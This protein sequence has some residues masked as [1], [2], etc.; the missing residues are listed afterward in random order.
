MNLS[1]E[2]SFVSSERIGRL[3]GY[4][5]SLCAPGAWPTRGDLDPAEIKDLLPYIVISEIELETG[6]VFYR[7]VGTKIVQVS[8]ID[9]TGH[10][11]DEFDMA[12]SEPSIWQKGYDL[13]RTTGS[14]VYGKTHV[15]L[16]DNDVEFML[17][18]E[19]GMFPL[20]VAR[21]GYMQC[22]ALEDFGEI[23]H[24]NY[25]ALKPMRQR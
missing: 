23:R 25:D 5:E 11:L 13:V 18:E 7:L 14:P 8:R 16:R 20:S 19:F 1:N 10:W 4:W 15:P 9:F 3:R 24:I 22:I 2:S 6:R 12:A 21:E 17:P